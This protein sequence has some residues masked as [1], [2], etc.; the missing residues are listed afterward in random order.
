MAPLMEEV[1]Y[2]TRVEE[3]GGTFSTFGRTWAEV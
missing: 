3:G 1:F 2:L